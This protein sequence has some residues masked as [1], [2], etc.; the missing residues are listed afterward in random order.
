MWSPTPVNTVSIFAPVKHLHVFP[1]RLTVDVISSLA[2]ISVGASQLETLEIGGAIPGAQIHRLGVY[3]YRRSPSL[4]N[5]ILQNFA[6]SLRRLAV[7]QQWASLADSFLLF[8][9]RQKLVD[10]DRLVKIEELVAPSFAIFGAVFMEK[11]EVSSWRQRWWHEPFLP[12]PASFNPDDPKA[13]E[14]VPEYADPTNS[15]DT[16]NP[17]KLVLVAHTTKL[18][19]G[20][21][22]L[23]IYEDAYSDDRR[24]EIPPVHRRLGLPRSSGKLFRLIKE[25]A[26]NF[27]KRFPKME[28]VVFW[29]ANWR[30][31]RPPAYTDGEWAKLA[32]VEWT[33]E[34]VQE[35][36]DAF[37]AQGVHF[38][39]KEC[40]ELSFGKPCFYWIDAHD[41]GPF[42]ERPI[43]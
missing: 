34:E 4:N 15:G 7:Y 3:D 29:R 11:R 28:R 30:V 17:D 24:T 32:P 5:G 40:T 1:E 14:N 6:H 2:E 31:P 13:P 39:Y 23:E 8:G 25:F 36:K 27:R 10:L 38:V 33:D 20:L 37:W 21:K 16:R 19:P 12:M 18:S 41:L 35:A 9:P 26:F 22:V 43:R 42:V